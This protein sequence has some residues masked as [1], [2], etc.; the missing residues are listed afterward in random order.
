MNPAPWDTISGSSPPIG[1]TQKSKKYN[2]SAQ[3]YI[4]DQKG[5]PQNC[6]EAIHTRELRYPEV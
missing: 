1:P 6:K 2:L 5:P 3:N 4:A